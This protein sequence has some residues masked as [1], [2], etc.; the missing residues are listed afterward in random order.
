VCTTLS[1]PFYSPADEK[2]FS[3]PTVAS[4]ATIQEQDLRDLGFG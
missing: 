4:L 1:Y 2:Y 3:F